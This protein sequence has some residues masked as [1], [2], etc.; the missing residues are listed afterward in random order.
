MNHFDQIFKAYD[1]RG[2]AGEQITE[3][4]AEQL[5]RA[6]VQEFGVSEVAIGYDA[7]ATSPE[8]AAALSKG[9]R[10]EGAKA[11]HLGMVASDM[12][13]F[14]TGQYQYELGVMVT[15]SHNPGEYNGFKACLRDAVPIE[16]GPLRERLEQGLGEVTSEEM[17]EVVERDILEDWIAFLLSFVEKEKIP[18][19]KVVADAGNGVAG[20]VVEALFAELPQCELI[21]LYFEPDGRFPNHPAN[22]LVPENLIDLEGRME[23]E[24]ADLG[25][26]FDGDAD[27]VVLVDDR[28]EVVDGTVTTAMLLERLLKKDPHITVVYN[29]LMGRVVPELCEQYGA[30]GIRE[31][32]GHKYIKDRMRKEGAVFGGEHSAH[33][34]FTDMWYADS[35][36]MAAVMVMA[37]LGEE[38][39]KLSS[40]HGRYYKYR[41]SGEINF[42]IEDR[43]GGIALVKDAYQDFEQDEL[44]GVTVHG[45]GWWLNVRASNTEPLLRLN[46]EGETEAQVVEQ[47]EK[48]RGVLGIGD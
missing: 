21:P 7:R 46:V 12:V 17:G 9:V 38:G 24:E 16:F 15:A 2:I 23:Q 1:I 29:A 40:L 14:A 48:V 47:V 28:Y 34:Y 41:Q 4:F 31:K 43:A 35:G 27:R 22:P 18:A 6:L 32:V 3:E 13:Y 33:Y 20:R 26:A 39:V 37:L 44:D 36:I 11:I 45:D 30:K 5:G 19:M 8:L 10:S 25:L 42:Q